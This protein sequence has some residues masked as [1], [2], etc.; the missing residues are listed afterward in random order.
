MQRTAHR[1][2]H[3]NE[4]LWIHSDMWGP[5][6]LCDDC[7]WTAEDDDELFP[8]TGASKGDI[9]PFLLKGDGP[10]RVVERPQA[11]R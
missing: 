3:C 11:G 1:C 7:G 2:P 9:P 10:D 4:P 6:Y 8:A 5:Y